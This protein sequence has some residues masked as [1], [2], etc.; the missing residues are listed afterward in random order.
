[1][2]TPGPDA[3]AVLNGA[4]SERALQNTIICM[5]KAQGFLCYHTW[6]SRRSEYGFPDLVLVHP[7]RTGA[8]LI[9]AELKREGNDATPAQQAWLDAIAERMGFLMGDYVIAEVWRPSD[10]DR[11]Q[12]LLEG[13]IA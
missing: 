11:I 4:M 12:A 9:F 6:D 3:R 1:M 10:L 8:P 13:I 2:T 7:D 5:A